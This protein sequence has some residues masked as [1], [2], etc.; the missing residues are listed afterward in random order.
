[1]GSTSGGDNELHPEGDNDGG[2]AVA[3]QVADHS[4]HAG[5]NLICQGK[6]SSTCSLPRVCSTAITSRGRGLLNPAGGVNQK[7]PTQSFLFRE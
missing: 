1:M 7:E 4:R 3:D 2:H 5:E 6:G